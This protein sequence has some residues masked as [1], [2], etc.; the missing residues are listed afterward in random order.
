MVCSFFLRVHRLTMMLRQDLVEKAR[1]IRLGMIERCAREKTDLLQTDLEPRK[2][3]TLEAEISFLRTEHNYEAILRVQS[4]KLFQQKC[5][6]EVAEDK[7][8][9]PERKHF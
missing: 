6:I 4:A 1:A 7:R 3:A 8:L 9:Q 2:K 5:G